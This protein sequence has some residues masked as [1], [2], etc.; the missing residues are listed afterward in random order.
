[1]VQE[2]K[3]RR[4]WEEVVSDGLEARENK[5]Q[6][7]WLLGD[8]ATEVAIA[9]GGDT[10]GKYAYAI[11]VDKKTLMNY[12]T[13][14]QKFDTAT[15]S[16]YRKLSFSHFAALSATEKPE[17]WLE[18]ADDEEWSVEMLRKNVNQAYQSTNGP[19]IDDKPPKVYR[20]PECGLWRLEGMSSYE[21]CRGH[22]KLT[23]N[24]LK[25]T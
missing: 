15:R 2:Q 6:T 13:V 9:Y 4:S 23:E 10:L 21:I 18:K 19:K 14:S 11:S 20:C 17:A 12:R 1:M 8:L 22:Y 24:G 5:D 3:I 16:K 25:Y 7:A